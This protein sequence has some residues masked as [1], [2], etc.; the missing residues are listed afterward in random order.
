MSTP[1]GPFSVKSFLLQVHLEA[2]SPILATSFAKG[3]W[4]G[5]APPRI[6]FLAWL[7]DL[8]KL[9]TKDHLRRFNILDA[10]S[11]MCALCN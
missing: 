7:V 8:E 4:W 3:V 11:N 10:D 5:L 6:E 9:N 1:W 2:H